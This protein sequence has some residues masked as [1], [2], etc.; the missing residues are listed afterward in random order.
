MF[1]LT[2]EIQKMGDSLYM[3]WTHEFKALVVQGTSLEDAKK[4][5]LISIRAKVAYDMKLPI[6]NVQ[7]KEVTKKNIEKYFVPVKS[8]ENQ[9]K[10]QFA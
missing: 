7:A 8:K 5:L 3:A 6:K 2:A 1:N 9:Y 10:V 4:E